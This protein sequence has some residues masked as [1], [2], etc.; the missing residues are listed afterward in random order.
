MDNLHKK[1][2]FFEC[3]IG[4]VANGAPS[5][6]DKIF[7]KTIGE[8]GGGMSASDFVIKG[9]GEIIFVSAYKSDNEIKSV[10]WGSGNARVGWV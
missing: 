2:S 1:P 5:N 3:I 4:S 8:D 9:D 10:I 6:V 7:D